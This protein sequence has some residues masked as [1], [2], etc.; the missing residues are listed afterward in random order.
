MCATTSSTS[1]PESTTFVDR[2]PLVTASGAVT[3]R[4]LIDAEA[5]VKEALRLLELD[6]DPTLRR[7]AKILDLAAARIRA[8]RRAA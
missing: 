3:I 8:R 6:V 2:G 5:H 4:V 1:L 7:E